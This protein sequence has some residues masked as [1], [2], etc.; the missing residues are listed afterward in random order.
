M[1]ERI[2]CSSIPVSEE[3]LRDLARNVAK[4]LP[5]LAEQETESGVK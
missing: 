2:L 1:A 5:Q 3:I 4:V